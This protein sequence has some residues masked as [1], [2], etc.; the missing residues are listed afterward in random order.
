MSAAQDEYDNLFR[1]KDRVSR[2]PED[3]AAL[4]EDSEPEPP[5]DTY[6]EK[7]SEDDESHAD[8]MRSNYY[9]P[10]IRSQANTGPKGVIADAHAFEQAKRD[11]RFAFMR[12]KDT[13]SSNYR[14]AS[15]NDEK[16]SEEEGEEGFLQRWRQSRLKELQRTGRRIRSRTS[17]P[18]K[19]LYGSL[20]TVDGDGY[21][22]AIEKV[23]ADTVVVVFI[24]DDTVCSCETIYLSFMTS[25]NATIVGH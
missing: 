4:S 21:L 22:D 7:D 1:D 3:A 11:Q 23:P 19:R 16:S 13:A 5:L 17:S 9:L 25:A 12:S 14:T 24:Y 15:Y 18:S 10:S 8:N 6:P 20:I 2:H